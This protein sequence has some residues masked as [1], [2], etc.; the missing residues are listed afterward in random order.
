MALSITPN[1]TGKTGRAMER[2]RRR[3]FQPTG[4]VRLDQVN[5]TRDYVAAWMHADGI[6]V[7]KIAAVLHVQVRAVHLM[8]SR[9]GD[10][11]DAD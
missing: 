1:T 7:W 8:I 5:A 2:V 4:Q 11:F 6:A 9:H 3:L 10:R